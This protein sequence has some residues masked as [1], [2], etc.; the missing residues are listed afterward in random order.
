MAFICVYPLGV[1]GG[2][3]KKAAGNGRRLGKALFQHRP[4]WPDYLAGTARGLPGDAQKQS[5]M[6]PRHDEPRFQVLQL[7]AHFTAKSQERPVIDSDRREAPIRPSGE[8]Y[9]I[10]HGRC[11]SMF[12]A[13]ADLFQGQACKSR[14]RYRLYERHFAAVHG[15]EAV[16]GL[17]KIGKVS[18]RRV[19]GDK[20]KRRAKSASS[21]A[22]QNCPNSGCFSGLAASPSAYAKIS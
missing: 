9:L 5:R 6:F 19:V 14:Q 1:L 2:S 3:T 17:Q 21:A 16:R 13:G 7:N 20:R 12:K 8:W 11:P 18:S 22:L 4:G 10:R 15:S